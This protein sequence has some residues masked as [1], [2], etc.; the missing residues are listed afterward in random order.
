VSDNVHVR[1]DP[2]SII[3]WNADESMLIIRGSS[4]PVPE[5]LRHQ[6]GELLGTSGAVEALELIYEL[7]QTKALRNALYHHAPEV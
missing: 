7:S 3:G 5:E 4:T 1:F 2:D 6:L